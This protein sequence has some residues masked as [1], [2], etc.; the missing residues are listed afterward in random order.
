MH[1]CEEVRACVCVGVGQARFYA[2]D[3]RRS[4]RSRVFA[5]VTG[6]LCQPV[7]RRTTNVHES[8]ALWKE[9]YCARGSCRAG[10][11]AG[12]NARKRNNLKQ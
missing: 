5:S 11:V 9:S 10:P 6:T 2:R 4:L 7:N 8:L 3:S 12:E 1:V